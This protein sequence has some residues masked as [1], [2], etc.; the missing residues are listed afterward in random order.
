MASYVIEGGHSLCGEVVIQGSKNAVLPLMAASLMVDG[1]VDLKNCPH[2]SDVEAMKALLIEWGAVVTCENSDLHIDARHI[3]R[4]TCVEK[5]TSCFRGGMLLMGAL[6]ARIGRAEIA[7]PGGCEIGLRP[8]DL[9]M[10]ALRQLGTVIQIG[11]TVECVTGGLRGNIIQFRFPSVGATQNAVMAAV[12]AKGRTEII[13]AAAEP[14]VVELCLFLNHAGAQIQGIGTAHLLI[15]GVEK[16]GSCEWRVSSDRIVAGTYG[17]AVLAAGGEVILR[18]TQWEQ[19]RTVWNL[20]QYMGADLEFENDRVRISC[21]KQ[22][23]AIDYLETQV[24]PGFP[25]DMQSQLMVCMAT[26]EGISVVVER[27][28][29]SR[30][31]IVPELMKMGAEIYE[32]GNCAVITGKK[33]LSGAE[34]FAKDLRGGAAL[35][36]AG[37]AACGETLVHNTEY[38][39]RGYEDIVRDMTCLGA[40]IVRIQ[41]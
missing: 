14:E 37:I 5:K 22:L 40:N 28:F 3:G 31:R 2:I 21:N 18:D 34:V 30:F 8:M 36:I 17:A 38:V 27:I 11:D 35:V 15:D 12:L 32:E 39:E 10:Y 19:L 1:T 33:R 26:A 25:T 13:N 7:Y 29:E 4:N 9:H 24:Y 23:K 41:E 20:F 6:T 16:L